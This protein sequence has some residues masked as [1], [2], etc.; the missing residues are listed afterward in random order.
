LIVG[1]VTP[2]ELR[3]G[4]LSILALAAAAIAWN[5]DLLGVQALL[6]LLNI[7]ASR[8]ISARSA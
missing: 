1:A 5:A 6:E 8:N 2:I 4:S 3:D 7:L